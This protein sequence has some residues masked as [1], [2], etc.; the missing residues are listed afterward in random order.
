MG[1]LSLQAGVSPLTHPS[2][3]DG[4]LFPA[5]WLGAPGVCLTLPPG[6]EGDVEAGDVDVVEQ[7]GGVSGLSG[8]LL[9]SSCDDFKDTVHGVGI[10]QH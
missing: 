2:L 4:G 1:L 10:L 7:V 9:L 5:A 6:I 8:F 3:E